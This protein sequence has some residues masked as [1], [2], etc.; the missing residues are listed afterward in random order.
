MKDL[1]RAKDGEFSFNHPNTNIINLYTPISTFKSGI[2][3]SPNTAPV[4][5]H[6]DTSDSA[7]HFIV[8]RRSLSPAAFSPATPASVQRASGFRVGSL[9]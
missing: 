3:S 8:H 9:P 7:R 5:C 2:R 4:P 6:A 1:K